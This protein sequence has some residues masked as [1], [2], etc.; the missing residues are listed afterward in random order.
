MTLPEGTRL[1]PYRIRSPLGAGGMG[2]V[3]RAHDTRLDRSVA[4]KVL[5]ERLATDAE[6]LARFEG[7]AKA[8][9][10]LSHPNILAIH[11]FGKSGEISYAVTELL[12]G[13]TLR[14]RLS[15]AVIPPRKAIAYAQQIAQGLAAAHDRGIVHRD[16]KPENLFVT[17]DGIVK[18][19][20]FG[21]AIQIATPQGPGASHAP[22]TP[23]RTDPGTVLGTF[24]YMSP[25]QVRGRRV[26]AR[27]DLFALGLVLFEMLTGSSAFR[28][29]SP[30]ET[31]AAILRDDPPRLTL[32]GTDAPAD[33]EQVI[34][35]CLEKQP[36]ERFQSA[37]DLAFALHVL[38]RDGTA[39]RPPGSTTSGT[40]RLTASGR[41]RTVATAS[42]AVLPFRNLSTDPENAYF[43][44]GMTEEIISAL[45]RI[46]ALRVAARTS[47]F[48]FKDKNE[49]VR[50][51]GEKLSVR[52]VLEGSVR[53]AGDRI[54]ITAQLIDVADGYQVWSENFDRQMRDVFE[55]Q[56]EIARAISAALKVRLLAGE[57]TLVTPGT[58][59]IEAYN[60]Y[61]KGR[62]FFNQRDPRRAIESFEA[63]IAR[64]PRY[65]AAH[66]GLA[67]SYGIYGFY[68]GFPTR[69]AFGRA[70][71]AANRAR[72]LEPDSPDVHLSLGIIDHY[73]GWDFESEERHLR[74]AIAL[75]PETSDG[76]SWLSLLLGLV[77]RCDEA[78]EVARKAVRLE[79]LS[80]NVQTNLAWS[81]YGVRRFDDAH[82][83]MEK[84]LALDAQAMYPL[85]GIGVCRQAL[86]DLPGA[87]EAY[88]RS[89]AVTERRLT[90]PVALLGGALG[91]AGRRD[92]A[93]RILRELE[94][95][96]AR[97][98]VPP[99]HLSL[100]AIGLG[101]KDAA[102]ALLARAGEERNALFWWIRYSPLFDSLRS[103]P[104][105]AALLEGIAS[106]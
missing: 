102:L 68:G 14:R 25:E 42:I 58:R 98:Y 23:G 56:E 30:P 92:E 94:E 60:L 18:I 2:E 32:P 9:A 29:D 26:D 55:V 51:I 100:I 79:P 90:F 3:Y 99:L 97:E 10:A 91:A 38:E 24:A 67:E 48:A 66:T 63:A 33:L 75:A 45:S 96:H 87:I 6:A 17:V 34:L 69:E 37:R 76:Y 65:A 72:E 54:R 84:A 35:H 53:R 13:Q 105:F 8:V 27:S 64:D 81:Y 74:R 47:S 46:E 39:S 89:V 93:E 16:L 95:R 40:E 49:D 86:G 7:E 77:G 80:A 106:E 41:A 1:G 59:D 19:L 31:M 52:T 103:D 71:S 70:R 12:D 61:L 28:R 4:I 83:E 82:R 11:D 43:S 44:D 73:Y 85:W 104:R 57:Q 5:P 50:S 36:E 78:L 21:L 62:Y 101:R 15:E 20:D 88:T 22:T